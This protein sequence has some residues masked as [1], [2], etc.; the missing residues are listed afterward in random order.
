MKKNTAVTIIILAWDTILNTG[1]TG[2]ADITLRAIGDGAEFTPAGSAVEVDATHLPGVYK[3]ALTTAENNYNSMLIGGKSATA[4]IS[5]VPF[6]WI[7]ESEDFSATEKASI[8]AAVPTAA[9][10]GTDAAAKVLVTPAQKLAT[11]VS[12]QVLVSDKTGFSLSATGADLILKSSTFVQAIVAAINEFATYGLTALNTLLV[13]TGIKA[14]S[15]PAA[16]LA[17]SQHV[18]VDSGTVTTLTNAP[19]APADMALN[20]TVMKA[21]NYTAPDN[22][23]IAAILEDTGTTIPVTLATIDSIVDAIKLKTDTLGGAGAIRVEYTVT[24][25]NTLLPIAGVNV[26]ITTDIEGINV[27]ATG[28]T[29]IYGVAIFYLNAGTVYV[30]RYKDKCTLVNPEIK[31]IS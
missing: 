30:F 17:A 28:V 25:T 23:S 14:A 13:T 20:S 7:N 24:D 10:I 26:W 16:T 18:I 29:D 11:D 5:I 2:L 27:I 15:I 6:S 3:V 9:A 21:A 12:G 31:I 4:N 19:P 1:K 22:A 8:A